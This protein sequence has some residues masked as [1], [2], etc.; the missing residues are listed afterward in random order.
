MKQA[1]IW[2]IQWMLFECFI[3]YNPVCMTSYVR[4]RDAKLFD[5]LQISKETNA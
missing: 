4:N 5:A 2:V 1:K 3:L